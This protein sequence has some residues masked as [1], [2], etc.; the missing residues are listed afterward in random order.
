MSV[1]EILKRGIWI[2]F[3]W[4]ICY[5]ILWGGFAKIARELYS[6]SCSQTCKGCNVLLTMKGKDNIARKLLKGEINI[7]KLRCIASIIFNS[8]NKA[9]SIFFSYKIPSLEDGNNINILYNVDK[10]IQRVIIFN[11]KIFNDVQ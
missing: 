7:I 8:V 2:K 11:C 6:K 10:F 9:Q 4:G 3:T 5:R 1:C